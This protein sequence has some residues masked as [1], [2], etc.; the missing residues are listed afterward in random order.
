VRAVAIYVLLG[1]FVSSVLVTMRRHGELPPMA[2]PEVVA[3]AALWPIAVLSR[4]MANRA[5]SMTLEEYENFVLDRALQED[6]S[7]G[8]QREKYGRLAP[9][10]EF[11]L[12]RSG[13]L[14]CSICKRP[15]DKHRS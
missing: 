7:I 5:G 2:W 4:I 3:T 1:G 12:N 11:S 9:R 10:H 13:D 6:T 14:R 15:V 8:E